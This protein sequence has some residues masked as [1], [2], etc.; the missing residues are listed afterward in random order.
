MVHFTGALKSS[1]SVQGFIACSVWRFRVQL[2][3]PLPLGIHTQ[4]CWVNEQQ[5]VSLLS[6]GRLLITCDGLRR[7]WLR[8][9]VRTDFSIFPLL[10]TARPQLQVGSD[11]HPASGHLG[12]G[13]GEEDTLF[14][15]SGC[16]CHCRPWWMLSARTLHMG[17]SWSNRAL[18]CAVRLAPLLREGF[19]PA[20]PDWENDWETHLS[21]Q[22]FQLKPSHWLENSKCLKYIPVCLD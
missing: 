13:R 4:D 18:L 6:L 3:S 10:K 7:V 16:L 17:E 20:L 9:E 15:I 2:T 11:D 8:S 5:N 14:P 12:T 19:L 1:H 22:S 21:C